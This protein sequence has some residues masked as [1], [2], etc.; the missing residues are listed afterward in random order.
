MTKGYDAGAF[1]NPNRYRP[2]V[3][4]TKGKKCS[5]ERPIS[6][7]NS[8]FTFVSQMRSH[9]PDPIGGVMWWG[10]DD[11]YWTCYAPLYCGLK[12][13]SS[14]YNTG[15]IKKFSWDSG[16]WVFNIVSNYAMLRYDAMEADM[17]VVQSQLEN[18]MIARQDS[19]EKEMLKV[20]KKAGKKKGKEKVNELLTTYSHQCTEMVMKRWTQ[21]AYEF[22]TKYNDGY[23]KDENGRPTQQ[24][25]PKEHYEKTLEHEPDAALPDWEP[26][27]EEYRPY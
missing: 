12:E 18:L 10:V 22:F 3:W 20:Y 7:Y 24:G 15:D 13:M 8:A 23:V 5:W 26:S 21:L 14:W 4:E 17:Q 2:L 9:L 19:V 16:W 1:G 6:T 11:S 25:Y 27:K